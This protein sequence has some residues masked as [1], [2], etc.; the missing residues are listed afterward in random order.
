MKSASFKSDFA[1]LDV[2]TGR[3]A[4]QKRIANSGPV[5]VLVEMT[6]DYQH[7][8]DDGTSI[9]FSCTVNSVKE[10]AS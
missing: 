4:L 9:E 5:R 8:R 1:I 3:H 6:L 2:K 7:G 10:Y